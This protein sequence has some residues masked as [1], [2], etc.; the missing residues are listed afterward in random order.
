[1]SNHSK[2]KLIGV[3]YPL[4]QRNP[5]TKL[6][7]QNF[8]GNLD[9]NLL[10]TYLCIVQV[11]LERSVPPP[12]PS[13]QKAADEPPKRVSAGANGAHMHTQARCAPR[14]RGRGCRP[15][16]NLC[17]GRMRTWTDSKCQT[18]WFPPAIKLQPFV[19]LGKIKQRPHQLCILSP[20]GGAAGADR[21]QEGGRGGSQGAL[22]PV[23]ACQH[24]IPPQ[25]PFIHPQVAE[26][27]QSVSAFPGPIVRRADRRPV[28]YCAADRWTSGTVSNQ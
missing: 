7:I 6:L 14:R 23:P 9:V 20:R 3:H 18:F 27:R 21:V 19:G 17:G 2:V 15:V 11:Q 10:M 22:L 24:I 12:P 13:L 25:R 5:G 4:S 26:Q 16:R 28:C 1:M 8:R